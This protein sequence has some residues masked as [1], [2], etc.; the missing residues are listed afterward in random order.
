MATAHVRLRKAIAT[1]KGRTSWRDGHGANGAIRIPLGLAARELD[2]SSLTTKRWDSMGAESARVESNATLTTTGMVM[3]YSLLLLALASAPA[4]A[5]LITVDAADYALGT[6]ISTISPGA[7][8]STYTDYGAGG[9]RFDPVTVVTNFVGPDIAPHAF[10]HNL[11]GNGTNFRNIFQ[12]AEPCLFRGVCDPTLH[13]VNY[14]YALL[15]AF[16]APTDYVEVDV[17][18]TEIWIDGSVLR[19]YDKAGN[20]LATCRV[21]GTGSTSDPQL[22]IPGVGVDPLMPTC[23]DQY[24]RY[25][26]GFGGVPIG[27]CDSRDCATDTMAFISL[28]NAAISYVMW[29][30]EAPGATGS[31][32]SRLRYNAVGVPEPGSLGLLAVGGLLAATLRRRRCSNYA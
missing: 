31:T 4:S 15:V 11:V 6:D 9:V 19:A 14:F 18:H 30:G 17:H 13:A 29:G 25:E 3:R 26:S 1:P 21:R 7:T 10:G 23:G 22:T 24:R 27:E 20:T 5:T 32:I 8:F 16:D 12:G 2:H 28:P